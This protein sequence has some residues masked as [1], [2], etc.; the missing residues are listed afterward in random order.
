MTRPKKLALALPL[1][2]ALCAIVTGPTFAAHTATIKH[3][4]IRRSP[5]PIQAASSPA[6]PTAL[7]AASV[8]SALIFNGNVSPYHVARYE[9][10]VHVGY[11]WGAAAPEVPGGTARH[12]RYEAWD[13][14]W[15]PGRWLPLDGKCPRGGPP[16]YPWLERHHPTWLLWKVNKLGVPTKP[17]RSRWNPGPIVDFTNPAVQ[18]YWMKHYVGPPLKEGFDGI[19]WDGPLAFDPYG[20]AGHFDAR[21]HFVHQYAGTYQDPKWA[22]AQAQALGTF[23]RLS[24]AINPHVEFALDQ[25]LDCT[26]Q[27]SLWVLPFSYADTIVDE[28]GY[29]NWGTRHNYI[30]SNPGAFCPNQWL[31]KTLTYIRMQKTGTR[32]VLIDAEPYRVHSYMTDRNAKARADFEWAFANYLLIKYSHTY[33]WFGGGFQYGYPVFVQRQELIDLGHPLG[34]MAPSQGLYIRWFTKGMVLV[35]PSATLT[36]NVALLPGKYEY[37]NGQ[38]INR[39]AMK[40]HSGLVLLRAS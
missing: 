14:G 1:L 18:K 5:A 10:S 8:E 19:A 28:E 21:H 15:C 26:F 27:E 37:Q 6:R 3:P 20:A 25:F 32:L 13:Q 4:V 31:E 39:V 30:S 16:S 17:A 29:T 33:F 23:L 35:N 24:R 36:F 11:V 40:P 38:K 7:G 12:D 34:D 2:A 22:A 9:R